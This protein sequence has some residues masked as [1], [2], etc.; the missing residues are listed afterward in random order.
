MLNLFPDKSYT[1]KEELSKQ[2]LSMVTIRLPNTI[3]HF[4][5]YICHGLWLSGDG[6]IRV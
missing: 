3:L 1:A 6:S 5:S 2:Q 4:Y